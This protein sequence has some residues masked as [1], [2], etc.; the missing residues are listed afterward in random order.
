MILAGAASAYSVRCHYPRMFA[1]F[2]DLFINKLIYCL[3]ENAQTGASRF[4]L[5]IEIVQ[6]LSL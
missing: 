1:A 6:Y 3:K 2:D 4:L 5:Y